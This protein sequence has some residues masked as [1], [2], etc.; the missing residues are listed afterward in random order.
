[1]RFRIRFTVDELALGPVLAAL[2]SH[3]GVVFDHLAIEPLTPPR[4]APSPAKGRSTQQDRDKADPAKKGWMGKPKASKAL[5]AREIVRQLLAAEGPQPF[6]RIKAALVSRGFAAGG[7]GSLISNKMS[8]AYGEI[9][10]LAPG[11]WSLVKPKE[12]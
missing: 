10:S 1:M 2:N 7:V 5:T 8:R 3:D 11:V 9:E 6:D 12:D 4:P